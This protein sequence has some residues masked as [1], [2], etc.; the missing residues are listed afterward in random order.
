M[1]RI[2]EYN[3]VIIKHK[4]YIQYVIRL[5]EFLIIPIQRA[6]R[7]TTVIMIGTYCEMLSISDNLK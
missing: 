2:F 4:K 5:Q 6:V 1:F 7:C 3:E